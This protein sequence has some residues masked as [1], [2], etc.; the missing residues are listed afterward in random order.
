MVVVN[1]RPG[2]AFSPLEDLIQAIGIMGLLTAPDTGS[3]VDFIPCNT[4]PRTN[5]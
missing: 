5:G 3:S 1:T 4:C 2:R